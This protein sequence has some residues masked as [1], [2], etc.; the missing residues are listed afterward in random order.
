MRKV[1]WRPRAHLDRESIAIYL[2]VERQ[3]PQAALDAIAG[4]DATVR[5]IC[6]FPEIGRAFAFEGLAHSDYRCAVSGRYRIFYRFTPER[7]TI[8]RV[9][10]QHQNIDAY[11]LI[12]F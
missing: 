10:H 3:N 6:E 12:G 11:S 5:N 9:L 1:E 2:G 7:V 4:I 8:Y